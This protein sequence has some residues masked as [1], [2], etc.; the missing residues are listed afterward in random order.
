[1][2]GLHALLHGDIR[3]TIDFNL[4]LLPSLVVVLLGIYSKLSGKGSKLWALVNRPKLILWI[5][6]VFWILR[7]IPVAPFRYLNAAH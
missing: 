3:S 2:R 1:M 4:L 7:N 6:V 5:V